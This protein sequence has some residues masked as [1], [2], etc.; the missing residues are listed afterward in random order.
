MLD[1]DVSLNY[2]GLTMETEAMKGYLSLGEEF[3]RRIDQ[4]G[5][6]RREFVRRSGI[7]RQTLHKIEHEGHVDL[8][9]QT[10]G[11]L[12]EALKWS[13]GTAKALARGELHSMDER[14]ALSLL[15]REG[16][17]RWAVVERIHSMSLASLE[18]LVAMME[19]EQLGTRPDVLLTTDEV[20]RIVEIKVSE[21]LRQQEA[22]KQGGKKT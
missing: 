14:D 11:Q 7:S 20:I 13:P 1:L 3:A 8:W 12:D 16:A 17:Y 15:D 19:G 22:S 6:S 10:Y 18:K 5:I 9:E 21:A 2:S 4:L